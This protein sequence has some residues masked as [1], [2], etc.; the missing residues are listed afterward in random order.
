MVWGFV[1]NKLRRHCKYSYYSDL[2]RNF[3]VLLDEVPLSFV[4]KADRHSYRFI[5]SGYRN[6]K[7]TG[8]L[9]DYIMKK[10]S[11][12]RKIRLL[13]EAEINNLKQEYKV[14]LEKKYV[15]CIKKI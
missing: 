7:F 3:P 13:V 5:M 11:I 9:F 4:K 1:K 15:I 10:Y 2:E 8:P 6:T 12:H 14:K